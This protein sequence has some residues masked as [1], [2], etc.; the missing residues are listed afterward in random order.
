MNHDDAE[1][2]TPANIIEL[3]RACQ[4]GDLETIKSLRRYTDIFT[5]EANALPIAAKSGRMNVVTYLL[6]EGADVHISD[7]LAIIWASEEGHFDVVKYLMSKEADIHEHKNA[8]LMGAAMGGHTDIVNLLLKADSG[9]KLPYFTYGVFDEAGYDGAIRLAAKYGHLETL[10]A[11][12]DDYQ[13]SCNM[14]YAPL[15]DTHA[16][17]WSSPL[18]GAIES[19]NLQMVQYL[20]EKQVGVGKKE[21]DAIRHAALYG[22]VDITNYLLDTVHENS[23]SLEDLLIMLCNNPLISEPEI[24]SLL[25]DRGVDI[26]TANDK[27]F[28]AACEREVDYAVK[29]LFDF[30]PDYFADYI[31]RHQEDI[32]RPDIIALANKHSL[33]GKPIGARSVKRNT[34]KL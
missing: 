31:K 20:V 25:I 27:P 5:E 2:K 15:I 22:R 32:D 18:V 10:K 24:L 28:R 34:L 14:T 29:A 23:T 12:M 26:H 6:D 3:Q 30:A 1:S 33:S 13:E 9:Q 7:D 16:D 17:K 11:L 21:G 4:N 19:N 8:A